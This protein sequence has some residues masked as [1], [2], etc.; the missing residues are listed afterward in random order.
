M[1]ILFGCHAENN[2][3]E[4]FEAQTFH[5]FQD[6]MIH[7]SGVDSII[8]KYETVRVGAMENG[9]EI[10]T[11]AELPQFDENVKITARVNLR[12]IPKDLLSVHDKWDRAGHVRLMRNDS[13]DVEIMKFM[14]AYG[15]K[16]EWEVDVSHLAPLLKGRCTFVGWI[17]TWV[18]PAWR[19]D[20]SLIFEK[21]TTVNPDWVQPILY[22]NSYNYE[23]PGNEGINVKAHIPAGLQKVELYY[24]VSGHCTDGRGADE[25]EPKDNVFN[26]DNKDV[27]R[28]RP[29]RTDCKQFRAINPYTKRWSNGDW[30]SDFDRTNWCPADKVEPLIYDFTEHL[31]PGD[32]TITLTIEDVRP[33]DEN[34]HLG[35]WRTSAYL[36]GWK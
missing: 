33:K 28:F 9:R 30:S 27:Y 25:F 2:T 4:D 34:G 7:F 15:G 36:I 5:L 6:N 21:G 20:F 29:W 13:V 26:I 8:T 35:Y 23:E 1:I 12:P 10:I 16:T 3:Q 17:D 31:N 24:L 11:Q 32:H 19:M 22:N 18:S 14:T